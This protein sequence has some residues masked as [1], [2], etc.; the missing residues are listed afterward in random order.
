MELFSATF[1]LVSQQVSDLILGSQS[2]LGQL[3][4][5]ERDLTLLSEAVSREHW[6]ISREKFQLEGTIW[7]TIGFRSTQLH[8]LHNH[9]ELLRNLHTYQSR[10]SLHVMRS[11]QT[12][13]G[14]EADMSLLHAR[15]T[16]PIVSSAQFFSPEAQLRSIFPAVQRLMLARIDATKKGEV[17]RQDVFRTVE[18]L[19]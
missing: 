11:V 18:G 15:V 13:E 10:A 5:L 6:Q 14:I 8:E 4:K 16:A 2:C 12:L 9:L 1:S 3:M 7:A 17:I 19:A